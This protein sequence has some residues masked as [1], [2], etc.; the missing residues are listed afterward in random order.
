MKLTRDSGPNRNSNP[1]NQTSIC[2]NEQKYRTNE[3]T[4]T[5]KISVLLGD[6]GISAPVHCVRVNGLN[7]HWGSRNTFVWKQIYQQL[8]VPFFEARHCISEAITT[9]QLTFID[10]RL[11]Q[12][13]QFGRG[14]KVKKWEG[15]RVR[16]V[17]HRFYRIL[18]VKRKVEVRL[19]IWKWHPL[20]SGR[21]TF[22][23]GTLIKLINRVLETKCNL[24]YIK[25]NL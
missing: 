11:C 16:R 7:F 2:T 13:L 4:N 1:N 6:Q 3:T 15:I 18:T 20:G 17:L 19:K 24:V 12:D 8:Y 9:L 25:P 5:N 10:Q 22:F 21:I 14:C 23:R